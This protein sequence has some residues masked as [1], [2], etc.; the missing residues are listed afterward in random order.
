MH[1]VWGNARRNFYKFFLLLKIK[2]FMWK[3]LRKFYLKKIPSE[4]SGVASQLN[5]IFE[6][7]FSLW[8]LRYSILLNAAS[9]L[10]HFLSLKSHILSCSDKCIGGKI[11]IFFLPGWFIHILF[12][13]FKIFVKMSSFVWI[14]CCLCWEW[15][16]TLHAREIP[17]WKFENK[18]T[19]I[20]L[21]EVKAV[22]RRL[23]RRF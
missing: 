9:H 11:R 18:K 14:K 12:G 4:I 6:W 23:S 19:Y 21:S 20:K 1:V 7:A 3:F 22:S 13:T 10:S 8:N 16:S 5:S 15:L 17:S 2:I